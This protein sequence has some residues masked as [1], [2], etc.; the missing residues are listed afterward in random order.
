M[1][2]FAG[3]HGWASRRTTQK[4]DKQTTSNR[5][6]AL[7]LR[8]H[9]TVNPVLDML[10]GL[11]TR[12]EILLLVAGGLSAHPVLELRG[13]IHRNLNHKRRT[14]ADSGERVQQQRKQKRQVMPN[15]SSSAAR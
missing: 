15:E 13:P 6:A 2:P 10:D 11:R 7:N 12:R 3:A 4:H 8:Q 14:R 9:L 1:P 5:L